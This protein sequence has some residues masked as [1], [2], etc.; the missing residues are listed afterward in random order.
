MIE[1]A[2]GPICS[3]DPKSRNDFALYGENI[4]GGI[5]MTNLP[6]SPEGSF[7]SRH[8]DSLELRLVGTYHTGNNAKDHDG[9][10]D[11]L[12]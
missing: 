4:Y 9:H 8:N 1:L 2:Q 7:E 10:N 6:P 12:E 11:P 3:S 5:P